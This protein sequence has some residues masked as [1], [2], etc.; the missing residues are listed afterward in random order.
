MDRSIFVEKSKF[1]VMPRLLL[2][3]TIWICLCVVLLVLAASLEPLV[4]RR[5]V[6]ILSLGSCSSVL[7][8]LVRLYG[9]PLFILI[10]T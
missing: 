3:L 2:P 6:V 7:P 10:V 5:N 1:F 4:D 8:E 9:G